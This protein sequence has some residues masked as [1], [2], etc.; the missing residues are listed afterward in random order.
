[1]S[2][3]IKMLKDLEQHQQPGTDKPPVQPVG[4]FV[5][6][7]IQYQSAAKSR[8]PLI[9]LI[10]VAV[11]LIPTLWFG[12]SMYRQANIQ[13]VN[14][15]NAINTSVTRDI[16]SSQVSLPQDNGVVV[17]PQSAQI[18]TE[19][20][21]QAPAQT[22]NQVPIQAST[23]E[24]IAE[25]IEPT[26]RISDIDISQVSNVS[27]VNAKTVAISLPLE[28][29]DSV[30]EPETVNTQN[31]TQQ[32]MLAS[33]VGTDKPIVSAVGKSKDMTS[34]SDTASNNTQATQG[35]IA[36]QTS[37]FLPAE[38]PAEV[39]AAAKP[40]DMSVNEVVLSK[41]QMAQ[42]QY[43]KAM[44]AEQAQRLDDAAGYYLEAII[45]QPSLHKARKQLVDIYFAQ[46]NPTTAM[47]LLE[48]GISM[49]PQQWEF[50]VILSQIQTA[51]KTYDEALTTVSMIPDNS[52]WA[53]D[54]W[55]AQTDLAQNSKNFTLAE[56]AY[57]N[58]LVS[59]STQSRW[60]MGLGYA[61]DSQQK[62]PQ[63]AQAY[64]SALS[65]E[66]LSTS[67]M[68]FIEKRLDQLGENR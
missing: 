62:Y 45:L 25:V 8:S 52:S 50:Y 27:V 68:T 2:V 48:S 67:A 40:V 32:A 13:M 57:R 58:L 4:E 39:P 23:P 56:E 61:L 47:R 36:A 20:L 24:I 42:L 12:V 34:L 43:R 63:A 46:N 22:L 55:I 64:R 53:R 21:T 66:G 65:Y 28:Q 11:L 51:I 33:T 59:E 29:Q 9:S 49:F 16:Q 5:R 15:P 14:E 19:V 44:D 7:Q 37:R 1:M 38:V 60:W 6:P 30:K 26:D 31:V 35:Q 54:K 41:T 3:I 10:V 18:S 17:D